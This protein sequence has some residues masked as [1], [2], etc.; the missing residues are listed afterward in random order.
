MTQWYVKDLSKLTQVSV[1]TLHHYDRIG[2]LEPSIRLPNGY[3]VYSEKDLLKLQQI[4]ALKYFGFELTQIKILLAEEVDVIHQF[5][6]QSQYLAEKAKTLLDASQ[7]LQTILSEC[8]HDKSIPWET[9]IKLIEVY[10]M[11]Q[12]LEKSWVAKALNKKEFEQFVEFNQELKTRFTA[13]D[14]QACEAEWAEIVSAVDANLDIDPASPRG[15][16]IAGRC[17]QWVCKLYSNKH[18]ALRVAVW[19]KGFKGGHGS[20]EHGLSA[21]SVEWLD[22]AM[23]AYH[24]QRIMS[25]LHKVETHPHEEVLKQWNEF[26]C[27]MYGDDK[28]LQAELVAKVLQVDM[29]S[30]VA[31]NWLKKVSK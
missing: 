4:I 18:A 24:R 22:K 17:L 20:E 30:Q 6:V 13:G 27:E 14:K 5:S 7:T 26:L 11:T 3:R 15:I 28:A 19:E 31:K 21:A 25:I 16:E 1:Q 8:N 2:L 9:I 29:L 23:Y 12:E 10:R